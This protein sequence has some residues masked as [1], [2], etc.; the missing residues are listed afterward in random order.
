M[1]A[2]TGLTRPRPAAYSEAPLPESRTRLSV[3]IADRREPRPGS[4]AA[5]FPAVEGAMKRILA[6]QLFLVAIGLFH[7][8]PASP[9]PGRQEFDVQPGEYAGGGDG[10]IPTSTA[11]AISKCPEGRMDFAGGGDDDEPNKITSTRTAH[12][13]GRNH[14]GGKAAYQAPRPATSPP[15]L[16][17]VWSPWISVL[18]RR[19]AHPVRGHWRGSR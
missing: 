5:A 2:V 4:T 16:R 15:S 7:A 8:P 12:R 14:F 13:L 9:D 3:V 1:F 18:I 11:S 10:D 19:L 6:C 17:E